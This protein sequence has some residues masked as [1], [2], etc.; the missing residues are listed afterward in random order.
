MSELQNYLVYAPIA[1]GAGVGIIVL[2]VL[3]TRKRS[4]GFNPPVPAPSATGV[5]DE[6]SFSNRRNN[7]RR[8]GKPVKIQVSSPAFRNKTDCGYVLDRST[9]GLRIALPGAVTPGSTMQVRAENAPDTVPWVTV[10]VRNCRN[11]GRHFELGCEFDQ[12]PPWNVLL[13]FG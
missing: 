4:T 9:S 2:V 3:S 8:E 11:A 13:L 1:V 5:E 7:H 10:V 6:N 12:T